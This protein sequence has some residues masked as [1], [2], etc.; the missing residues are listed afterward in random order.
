MVD[1]TIMQGQFGVRPPVTKHSGAFLELVGEESIRQMVSNHYD[2][3]VKSEISDLFPNEG[4][5]LDEA[6]Q[7]AADFVIQISGGPAYFNQNRGAPQMVGRH[8]PFKIT[9]E[10]RQVWL[11]LYIEEIEKLKT[12]D[13]E[14]LPDNVKQEFF[15]Y[16]NVFS[17][18]MVNTPA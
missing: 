4:Q 10:S 7:H 5:A 18:W 2:A 17:L 15:N 14:V 16:L 6:K 13:G 1:Y 9:P 3:L 11:K 12:K 8:A